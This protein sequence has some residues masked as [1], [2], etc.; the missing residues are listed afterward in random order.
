MGAGLE[1]GEMPRFDDRTEPGSAMDAHSYTRELVESQC[2]RKSTAIVTSTG[3]RPTTPSSPPKPEA[4]TVDARKGTLVGFPKSRVPNSATGTTPS[5]SRPNSVPPPA[6]IRRDPT[7]DLSIE[8]DSVTM[9]DAEALDRAADSV[10]PAPRLRSVPPPPPVVA[11]PMDDDAPT[12]HMIE[13]HDR[14]TLATMTVASDDDD[15]VLPV[16]STQHRWKHI[17]TRLLEWKDNARTFVEAMLE[18]IDIDDIANEFMHA[19]TF[20]VRGTA[21]GLRTLADR[22]EQKLDDVQSA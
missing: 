12:N 18:R 17:Q 11:S 16:T 9:V 1:M 4:R 19:T 10:R 21:T 6:P 20:V 8:D 2:V 14:E 13:L 15:V 22:I 5:T 3:S 7:M